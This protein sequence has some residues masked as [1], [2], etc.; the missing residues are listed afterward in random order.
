MTHVE[1]ISRL[2]G[3][4]SM[5]ALVH[6]IVDWV[7][8]THAEAVAKHNNAAVRARHCA[9]YTVGFGPLLIYLGLREWNLAAAMLILFL[10]HFIEDTYWPVVLWAKYIRQPPEMSWRVKLVDGRGKLW[11]PAGKFL[12]HVIPSNQW[13]WDLAQSVPEKKS[14]KAAQRELDR[15]G[16]LEFIGE[17]LGKILMIAIDQIVHVCFLVPIAWIA[18]S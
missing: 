8:Q 9:I 17:T 12:E 5:L 10:S 18:N 6:F 16:F 4:L 7:F 3:L 11:N 1:Q 15:R 2:G 14:L 13:R